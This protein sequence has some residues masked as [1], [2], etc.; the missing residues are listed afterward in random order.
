MNGN[1]YSKVKTAVYSA[2][3][4]DTEKE[5]IAGFDPAPLVS[6]FH[7]PEEWRT[8]QEGAA[9][10]E[11]RGELWENLPAVFRAWGRAQEVLALMAAGR[12]WNS[13]A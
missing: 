5:K 13:A 6:A 9:E 10:M 8:F 11:R 4:Y 2:V 1:D 12:F 7:T 3:I